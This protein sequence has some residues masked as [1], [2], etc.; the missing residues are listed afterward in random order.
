MFFLKNR[1]IWL[2]LLFHCLLWVFVVHVLKPNLDGYGEM[3]EVYAWGQRFMLGSFKHPPLS[4]WIT[5]A[6]FSLFPTNTLSYYIM[7]YLNAIIGVLGILTLAHL[8]LNQATAITNT[9]K[10]YHLFILLTLLFTLLSGAYS[11]DAGQYNADK[12]LLSFWP[13]ITVTFFWYHYRCDQVKAKLIAMVL[14]SILAAAGMLAKYFTAVLLLS[15][16]IISLFDRNMRAS[17]KTIYPYIAMLLIAILILP[18]ILWEYQMHFPS[19]QYIG[20]K[21]DGHLNV[22][23]IASFLLSMFYQL[24]I[25]WFAFICLWWKSATKTNRDTVTEQQLTAINVIPTNVWLICFLPIVITCLL[26]LFLQLGLRQHWA[27]PA[28]FA[29][30]ILMTFLLMNK[31]DVLDKKLLINVLKTIW[32]AVLICTLLIPVYYLRTGYS[33]YTMARQQMAEAIAQHFQQHFP[34]QTLSWAAGTWREPATLAFY[35]PNHPIALPG[36]PN[37]MPA[38]V[39]P[40]PN[41]HK[42]YGVILCYH[43]RFIETEHDRKYDS[44]IRDTI[45]WLQ[46]NDIAVRQQKIYFHPTGFQYTTIFPRTVTAFWIVP[47]N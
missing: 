8:F 31:L 18:H 39:N 26:G 36:Y 24:P 30:P 47:T 45:A 17:Y 12:S 46:H 32:A 22:L 19:N 4:G 27:F 20:S 42:E 23:R 9:S 3:I 13:W 11:Y 33:V 16:F 34:N 28:W 43:R 7:A 38:L 29:L 25:A 6:W 14:F 40:Y 21:F 44:C 1:T 15:L 37:Q 10:K 5:H 35:L 41:W 2:L